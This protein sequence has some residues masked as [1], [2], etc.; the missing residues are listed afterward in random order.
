MYN[1]FENYNK[2]SF[3]YDSYRVPI[4]IELIKS[5]IQ[6]VSQLLNVPLSELKLLDVG[7]GTGNYINKLE[8]YVGSITGLEYND[9]MLSKCHEKFKNSKNVT[10]IKGS[11]LDFPF[12]DEKFH[13]IIMN[14]VMHHLDGNNK[15]LNNPKEISFPNIKKSISQV[16]E[17]LVDGGKFLANITFNSQ[18]KSFWYVNHLIPHILDTYFKIFP[19]KNVLLQILSESGFG[20][21]IELHKINENMINEKYYYDIDL[22]HKQEFRNCESS[23]S[24]INETE[25]ESVLA[26]FEILKEEIGKEEFIKLIKHENDLIC[27][28]TEIVCTK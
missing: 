10:I 13:V 17:H 1:S 18:Q 23:W 4:A 19:R 11:A 21:K 3:D 26:K 22:V 6:K 25:L 12:K 9:G 8:D 5:E 27:N 24:L 14:Q 28:S 16:Y 20:N 15:L 2:T 7:C